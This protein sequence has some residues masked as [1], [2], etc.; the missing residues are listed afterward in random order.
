MLSQLGALAPVSINVQGYAP[1]QES[2]VP[3]GEVASPTAGESVIYKIPP[4]VWILVFMLV[5]YVG[6]RW[7]MED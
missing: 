4:A 7:V 2:L 6:M 5:G 3:V 1:Q